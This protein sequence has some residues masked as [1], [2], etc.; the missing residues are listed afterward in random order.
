MKKIVILVLGVLVLLIV[1][2]VVTILSLNL[3]GKAKTLS[4][5]KVVGAK[6]ENA[7]QTQEAAGGEE[8]HGKGVDELRLCNMTAAEKAAKKN[9]C[10]ALAKRDVSYCY[11]M[12][13]FGND[14]VECLW[15]SNLLKIIDTGGSCDIFSG[16]A[17][18]HCLAFVN[19][20][21][22]PCQSLEE[23]GRIGPCRVLA[24]TL[25]DSINKKD[26][27]VCQDFPSGDFTDITCPAMIL[28]R[29]SLC[30][31]YDG[32]DAKACQRSAP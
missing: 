27:S 5:P 26:A 17:K 16:D 1:V 2:F 12:G 15:W 24:L 7:S 31:T 21:V 10:L 11:G 9:E 6:Q 19:R 32:I 3:Y 8:A 18:R 20:D 30:D 29:E 28:Q 25:S 22:G 13:P 23:K 4:M 14:T